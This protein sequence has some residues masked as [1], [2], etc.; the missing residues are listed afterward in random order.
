MLK[1][2]NAET[3][4]VYFAALLAPLTISLIERAVKSPGRMLFN[5][6]GKP[7]EPR[8]LPKLSCRNFPYD[9]SVPMF[10]KRIHRD[11]R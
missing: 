8:Q 6:I 5:H 2:I 11:F 9:C 4:A 1:Q 3:I 10:L 7:L